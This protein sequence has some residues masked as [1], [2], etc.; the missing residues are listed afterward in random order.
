[1]ANN[2]AMTIGEQLKAERERQGMPQSKLAK[3]TGLTTDT[4]SR[5]ENNRNSNPTLYV[6]QQLQKALNFKFDL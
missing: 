5:I 6:V 4:I 3:E 1:M 2:K